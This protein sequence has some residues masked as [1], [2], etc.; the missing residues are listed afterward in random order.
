MFLLYL[1]II[2]CGL[3]SSDLLEQN[4]QLAED[5]ASLKEELAMYREKD[6]KL[7]EFNVR[8]HWRVLIL[9]SSCWALQRKAEDPLCRAA[10]EREC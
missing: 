7:S 1:V 4:Q 2:N 3:T 9:G 8:M 5:N 10:E 6:L